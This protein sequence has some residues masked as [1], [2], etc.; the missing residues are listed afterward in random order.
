MYFLKI[1][2]LIILFLI[3]S[4]QFIRTDEL[5][6]K[7]NNVT[8]KVISIVA[9]GDIMLGTN[10]P[11]KESLPPNDGKHILDEVKHI[12]K[13]ADLT[14]GNLEGVVLNSGGQPKKCNDSLYCFR[15]R[16]P[17]HYVKYLKDSGFD[18]L[19]IANNHI[20]DFGEAGKEKTVKVLRENGIYFAG[21]IEYPY[22]IFELEGLR[23][24][25]TAFAPHRGTINLNDY[26][27]VEKIVS[28]LDSL[29]N[30]VIVSFHAGGEG[31]NFRHITRKNEFYLGSDRGNPYKFV[32][33]AIDSGAD[34][35]LGHGPHVTRAV[36]LYKNRFIAYSL[37]NFATYGKFNLQGPNGM[38]PVIKI[39]LTNEGKFLKAEII[40]IMQINRGVP[41]IDKDNSAL[42]EL[43]YLTKYDGFD[44]N[45]VF[46]SVGK[47]I[48]PIKTVKPNH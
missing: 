38:A 15:F 23:I 29:C 39:F 25:F 24:G 28:H 5:G 46:D 32:R 18:L 47:V 33:I 8:K 20:N 43:I 36:D 19:S 37:G 13:D 27:T 40:S 31:K 3:T 6:N 11:S 4:S 9:V 16:M 2:A 10:Y 44:H 17:E 21:L 48:Y 45:F 1:L 22:M 26:K 12:T 35:L 41:V 14:F 30:I 34:L 7:S 42:K